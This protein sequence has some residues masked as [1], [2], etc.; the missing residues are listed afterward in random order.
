MRAGRG[1]VA[2]AAGLTVVLMASTALAGEAD[3]TSGSFHTFADGHA[4][5]YE[6]EGKA[7][8]VR[9]ADGKTMSRSTSRV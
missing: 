9:K 4:L 2:I 1:T 6:I 3:V 8:V 7:T 5:G